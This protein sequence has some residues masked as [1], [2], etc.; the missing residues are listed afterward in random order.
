MTTTQTWLLTVQAAAFAAVTTYATVEYFKGR[1]AQRKYKLYA[2]RDKLLGLIADDH[3]KECD[4]LFQIFYLAIDKSIAE[5]KDVTLVSFVK[6]S[7]RAKSALEQ[8]R[9]EQLKN[10]I[11]ASPT[12]VKQFVSAFAGTM[13][14][15]VSA[16]S[17]IVISMFT[18]GFMG[19]TIGQ[20]VLSFLDRP[21]FLGRKPFHDQR[22]Q[23]ATY[24]YFENLGAVAA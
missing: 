18:I 6:A 11:E 14:E 10:Q 9:T 12:E 17:P 4:P 1:R 2:M 20:H 15:I 7:L 3:I 5:V 19:H 16:N 22:E 13:M 23:V 24:K 8:E 21:F